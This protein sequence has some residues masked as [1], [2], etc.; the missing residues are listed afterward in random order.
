MF[1]LGERL[2]NGA[3][4]VDVPSDIQTIV[5]MRGSG[6]NIPEQILPDFYVCLPHSTS[7]NYVFYLTCVILNV[8]LFLFVKRQRKWS[9]QW[10]QIG[11][12]KY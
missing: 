1:Q 5:A 9:I 6:P 7:Y 11:G 3:E 4:R 12:G 10:I 2:A 8:C